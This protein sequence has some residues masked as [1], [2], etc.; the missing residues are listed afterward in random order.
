MKK[1]STM[2][3]LLVLLVAC[4]KDKATHIKGVIEGVEDGRKII[5][6]AMAAAGFPV[7]KDTI[8]ITGGSF[9]YEASLPVPETYYFF[10]ENGRGAIP[11]IMEPGTLTITAYKDSLNTSLVKGGPFNED[12]RGLMAGFKTIS[13]KMVA[14]RSEL[15]KA[16]QEKDTVLVKKL[17]ESRPALEEE[18]TGYQLNFIKTHPQSYVSALVLQQLL[19]AN[20]I[21]LSEAEEIYKKF[22]SPVKATREGKEAGKKLGE[23]NKLAVGAMAPDFSGKTPSGEPFSLKDAKGKVIVIDFWASW[24]SPCRVENPKLVAVYNKY[25]NKGLQIVGVSLDRK[26]ED[27]KKAIAYDGLTWLHVSNLK[28]WQDPIAK[29]YNVRAIPAMFLLNEKGVIIAKNL[30]VEELDAKLAELLP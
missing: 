23:L 19:L 6:K 11:V 1:I 2:A 5:V 13:K 26:A 30:K 16:S 12:L 24:C 3:G 8:E 28:F 21:P 4:Q 17:Q 10:M 27:W 20:K 14:W 7:N 9:H 22:P 25:R 15:I 29:T 18:S